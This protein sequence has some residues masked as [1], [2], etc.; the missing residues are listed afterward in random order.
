MS[1]LLHSGTRYLL[2]PIVLSNVAL[3]V[4]VGIRFCGE[5]DSFECILIMIAIAPINTLGFGYYITILHNYSR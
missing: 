4:F 5:N 1:P 2:K 3:S